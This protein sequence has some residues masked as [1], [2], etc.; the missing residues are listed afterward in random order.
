MRR[1]MMLCRNC[2][3]FLGSEVFPPIPGVQ[4]A[5]V[6]LYR[7]NSGE[8]LRNWLAIPGR[9]EA[10][11]E[12]DP[13]LV[14]PAI[15]FFFSHRRRSSGTASSVFAYR[16]RPG[17]Q[18]QFQDWR[19]RI[20]DVTR[21]W[22]G[23]LGTESFDTFDYAK[24]EHVVVVRFDS[25]EHLD[26]WLRSKQRAEF[27]DEVHNYVEDYQVRRIGSGFEGWFEYTNEAGPIAPWRQGMVVLTMLFP[28][29]MILRQ[30]F[31]PLFKVLPFPLAFLALLITDVAVL[32]FLVMPYF[33]R[34]MSFW[35]RPKPG[36]PWWSEL[37]GWGVL[38]GILGTTLTIT[39][40]TK[41]S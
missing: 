19:R 40:L 15:E 11:K 35:L 36:R 5:Y 30:V 8:A 3:G 14:A 34:W 2:H 24:P 25:R 26:G 18:A 9:A 22:E 31:A 32:T 1:L 4:D 21:T 16:V 33:T 10:L 17:F 13:L 6:V 38:L 12:M 28:I 37:A 7:F 41:T 20:L 29:I 23:F 39:L 27:L